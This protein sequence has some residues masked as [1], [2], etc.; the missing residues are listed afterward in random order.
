MRKQL[1]SHKQL[2][3]WK[4]KDGGF[5][6]TLTPKFNTQGAFAFLHSDRWETDTLSTVCN[7]ILW[8][9]AELKWLLNYSFLTFGDTHLSVSSSLFEN[10]SVFCADMLL[11]WHPKCNQNTL[12]TCPN[13]CNQSF[14]VCIAIVFEASLF[15]CINQNSYRTKPM[16]RLYCMDLVTVMNLK[17][18][19][20]AFFA[21]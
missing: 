1:H 4:L 5:S 21:E 6:A 19:K 16:S 9:L 17:C 2:R 18:C 11:I 14:T 8:N 3:D 20:N 12:H 10:G 13:Q 7:L 15:F